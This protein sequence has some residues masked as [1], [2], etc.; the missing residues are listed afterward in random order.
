MEKYWISEE[1]VLDFRPVVSETPIVIAEGEPDWRHMV[2]PQWPQAR[3]QT[4]KEG[5]VHI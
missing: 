1:K 4:D 2:R 5:N 3:R